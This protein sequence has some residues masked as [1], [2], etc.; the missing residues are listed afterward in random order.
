MNICTPIKTWRNSINLKSKHL[1]NTCI[2]SSS[3]IILRVCK[4]YIFF[5]LW[6]K[7]LHFLNESLLYMA[8]LDFVNFSS[9]HMNPLQNNIIWI[10]NIFKHW[11][12]LIVNIWHNYKIIIYF[13]MFKIIKIHLLNPQTPL[14][15]KKRKNCPDKFWKF[16]LV[17]V[18]Y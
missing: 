6:Q 8:K 10:N 17:F 18:I 3:I 2:I 4:H 5:N 14:T 11:N 12:N 16:E 13:E 1:I 9:D 7:V 15:N